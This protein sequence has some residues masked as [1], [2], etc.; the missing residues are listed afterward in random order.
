MLANTLINE[1][2]FTDGH[3]SSQKSWQIATIKPAVNCKIIE[4]SV[5]LF[6]Q[7]FGPVITT[8]V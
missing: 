5:R 3:I 1:I 8:I 7:V 4:Y 6:E 2:Q